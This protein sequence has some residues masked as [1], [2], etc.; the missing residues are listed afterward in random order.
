[1]VFLMTPEGTIKLNKEKFKGGQFNLTY[2]RHNVFSR[3]THR[4]DE[5]QMPL[6]LLFFSEAKHDLFYGMPMYCMPEGAIPVISTK[7]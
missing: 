4:C 3:G 2:S 6:F 5:A 1:M 7:A